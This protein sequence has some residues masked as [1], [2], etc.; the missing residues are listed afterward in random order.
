[1]VSGM[2]MG[3]VKDIM[4]KRPHILPAIIA[5]VML[6]VAIL[7]LPYGYYQFLRWIIC[8]IALF[9]AYKAFSYK[10]AW[11]A[12]MFCVIA[13]LFVP[14]FTIHFEKDIWMWLDCICGVVFITSVFLLQK[15]TNFE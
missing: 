15:P 11:V 7:P 5:A 10:K 8:G 12:I 4:A 14:I 13:V 2:S 1:M 3:R 9:I 6:F